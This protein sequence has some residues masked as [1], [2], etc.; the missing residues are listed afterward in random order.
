ALRARLADV[1]PLRRA[2]EDPDA[3]TGTGLWRD[4]TADG[5]LIVTHTDPTVVGKRLSELP[6]DPFATACALIADDPAA[7]MVVTM[8]AE[9]DVRTIMADPLIG[10]G[11]DNGMPVGLEHP[12]T[13]GCFPEFLGTYV[14]EAGI[15]PLPEAIRKMTSANAQPFAL[16]GRGVLLPGSH[17][18]ITVFDPS[19]V[20]HPGTYTTPATRPLGIP[21][22]LLEGTVTIDDGHFT[23]GRHGRILR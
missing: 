2:A 20:A 9:P 8:M 18:D 14:R 23:G 4:T 12:R 21:Y 19:T 17:A 22:V 16:H 10:V 13:W 3:R 1:E 7:Y 5:V 15:V 6:G 11:S